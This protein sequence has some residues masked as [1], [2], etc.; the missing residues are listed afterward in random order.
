MLLLLFGCPQ[1]DPTDSGKVGDTA[2]STDPGDS[3]DSDTSIP[4]DEVVD[5]IVIGGGPA[6]LAAAIEASRAGAKTVL[7]ERAG[8]AGGA[9]MWASGLMLFSGTPAQAAL[10]IT[11]SPEILLGEWA[12]FTGGDPTDTWV[13]FFAENNVAMVYDWLEGMGVSWYEPMPDPSAG[14]IARIHEVE[15][16]GP[17]LVGELVEEL[18]EG[19]VRLNAEATALIDGGVEWTPVDSGHTYTLHAGAVVIATGGFM[20][21]LD[22]VR[23]AAPELASSTLLYDSWPDSDGNGLDMLTELGASTQNLGAIGLYGHA[24]ADPDGSYNAVP[25][26]FAGTSMWVDADGA[27]FA[28]EYEINSFMTG[29]LLSTL[30]EGLAWCV[31]DQDS[32]GVGVG[33]SGFGNTYTIEELLDAGEAVSAGDLDTL[34]GLIGVDLLTFQAS[35]EQFNAYALEGAE[36]PWREP[37][38][39]A[40][41]LDQPPFY[42]VTLRPSV[43]KGFGGIDVDLSGR[44]LDADGVAMEHVYAAGELAGMAGGSLVGDYGFTGSLS[45]VILGGRVAGLAAATDALT[46]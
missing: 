37:G 2:D 31:A 4:E 33:V 18:P 6:G 10:G 3:E 15:G 16:G 29:S 45:A 14:E 41:A 32:V 17:A 11:D 12:S 5:V 20:H 30:P 35:A 26:L 25:V 1:A 8:S 28:D 23:L 9:A 19:L 46:P 21:D 22:R 27:R 13:E 39:P 36:D 24:I 38:A 43:A 44:V 42:A 7:L 34:G 40:D